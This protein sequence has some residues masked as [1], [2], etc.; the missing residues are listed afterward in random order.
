MVELNNLENIKKLKYNIKNNRNGKNG[1]N[2]EYEIFYHGSYYDIPDDEMLIP[3]T[4]FITVEN[5]DSIFKV[6]IEKLKVWGLLR[7]LGNMDLRKIIMVR[8][9]SLLLLN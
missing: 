7:M 9:K 1:K 2:G 3:K 4:N 8:I 6:Y 5:G